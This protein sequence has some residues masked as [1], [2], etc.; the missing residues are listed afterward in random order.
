[1]KN[2]KLAAAALAAAAILLS[3]CKKDQPVPTKA[4]EEE[5]PAN[6]NAGPLSAIAMNDAKHEAQ[7][8][9]GFYTVEAGAWRWTA[10]KFSVMLK[11][12]AGAA[13]N[14]G[15]LDLSFSIPKGNI[16]K[17]H[18]ITLGAAVGGTE[19]DPATFTKD[20]AFKFKREIPASLLSGNTVRIDFHLDKTI[21]PGGADQRDLGV[22]AQKVELSA[23]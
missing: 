18:S 7:L 17:L 3:A 22:V 13:Q 23:K 12:P 11:T 9:G 6:A 8:L 10:G 4:T 1:M 5:S 14:G 2:R 16:D 20:G 15:V 21:K 19:L